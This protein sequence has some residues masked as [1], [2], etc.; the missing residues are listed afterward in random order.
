V[1]LAGAGIGE[2]RWT[3]ERKRVLVESR[4]GPTRL[5][6][7]TLAGLDP[8]PSVLLSASGI[9]YYGDR[10]DEILTEDSGP[11]TG[12]MSE[13][14]QEWEA[15]TTPASDAGIRTALLRTS[16]A[17]TPDGGALARTLLPF[18]LGLGGRIGGGDQWWSW[19][20]IDDHID[21]LIH[22]LHHDVAGPV[23]MTAPE[24]VRNADY[25]KALGRE[26]GRPTV[27]PIPAFAPKLLFGSELVEALLLESKRAVPAVLQGSGF[28]FRQ[29]TIEECFAAVL[30]DAEVA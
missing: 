30:G 26:L 29:P 17:Q 13:L 19:I 28:T 12:F 8:T 14:C 2:K 6:A 3:D 10:G 5:L 24:P 27:I 25:T 11:G 7:E 23:N 4:V 1:H 20:S 22:L 21:A 9:D 16:P 18:K 15:A